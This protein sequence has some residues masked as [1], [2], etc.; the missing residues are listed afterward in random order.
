MNLYRKGYRAELKLVK[1]LKRD[2]RFHTV[3]RS[4][5][6][7][8]P[9]DVVAIGRSRMLLCQVKTG[10]GSFKKERRRVRQ[11]RVPRCVKKQIRI[12]RHGVW[13]KVSL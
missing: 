2:G 3:L 11:L 13:S 8:S 7:R 12:Y 5:G 10:K 1:M 6:S 4:A 9:F